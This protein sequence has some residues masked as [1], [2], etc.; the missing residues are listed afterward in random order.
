MLAA[1]A[2]VV[3]AAGT[4]ALADTDPAADRR[5]LLA[6][7]AQVVQSDRDAAAARLV[8]IDTPEARQ[9]VAEALSA[10]SG[11]A[12]RLAAAKALEFAPRPDP[13]LLPALAG[14]LNSPDAT[15][16]AAIAVADYQNLPDGLT[17]LEKFIET[18]SAATVRMRADAARAIGYRT[19]PNSA[20]YLIQLVTTPPN[21]EVQTA[22]DE[23]LSRMSGLPIGGNAQRWSAWFAPLR[24][25]TTEQFR[26]AVLPARV[27]RYQADQALQKTAAEA[28][29]EEIEKLYRIIPADQKTARNEALLDLLAS[30]D[31]AIR[32]AGVKLVAAE[33][34]VR[35][36]P[37]P[38][39][40]RLVQMIPD[41]D[42]NLRLEVVSILSRM[43]YSGAATELVK[44]SARETDPRV[45]AQIATALGRIEDPKVAE[46]LLKM[47]ADPRPEIATP[48][49]A[50][51]GGTMGGILRR[52]NPDL[53]DRASKQ[54]RGIIDGQP[55]PPETKQADDLRAAC[56]AA[57]AA[58]ADPKS[59]DT[60]KKALQTNGESP[61]VRK[62]ALL[63]LGNLKDTRA[64]EIVGDEL[65]DADPAIR[66]AA[67][68]ASATTATVTDEN[69]LYQHLTREH[70]PDVRRAEWDAYSA[71]F[72]KLSIDTLRSRANDLMNSADY[73]KRLDVLLAIQTKLQALHN[74]DDLAFNRLDIADALMHSQPPEPRKAVDNL[75]LAVAYWEGPGKTNPRSEDRMMSVVTSMILDEVAARQFAEAVAFGAEQLKARKESFPEVG[76]ALKDSAEKLLDSGDKAGASELVQL[77]LKMDPPLSGGVVEQIK[78][79]GDRAAGKQ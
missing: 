50:A 46:P 45:S 74:D 24:G 64:N 9:A 49:A 38:V 62:Q 66:L 13:A 19:D 70:D 41:G 29:A 55:P 47:V 10:R 6:P 67:A 71:L 34:S 33:F 68:K 26:S 52:V 76:L 28:A 2:V 51:L 32:T 72:G 25:M 8:A 44:Q 75:K 15:E 23:A 37:D 3:A 43:N 42:A 40:E 59:F 17:I 56:M 22:A 69:N 57:L 65:D 54:L 58:L 27:V 31:S 18:R 79:I 12:A 11:S 39:K 63:G 4:G 73:A 30:P 21:A 14:S 77:V 60:F 78:D 1:G 35:T 53:A 48:A 20:A 5:T 36:I 61:A 7:P 16:S